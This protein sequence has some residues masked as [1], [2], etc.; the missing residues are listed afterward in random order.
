MLRFAGCMRHLWTLNKYF[1]RY[2]WHLLLGILFVSGS[3]Y[4]KV[5]VPQTIRKALDFVKE[6]LEA[7]DAA[8]SALLQESLL[9]FALT[10]IG[11]AI[12]MGTFMYFMRQTI[13][14]M[15]RLIEYDIRKD[16]YEHFQKLDV[17]F[18]KEYKTGDIM[19]RISEDVSKV[20]MYV[21]P[22]ILYGINLVSL[23]ILVISSMLAVSVK[24]TLYTLLPLPFLSLSIYYVSTIIHKK[25]GIIQSQ[26]SRITSVSQEVYSGI[27]VVKSY[28]QENSFAK[29][30][31]D[32]SNDFKEKSLDLARV[33]ALFFPLMILLISSSTLLTIYIGGLEVVNGNITYGNI[34]EF[35]IYVNYLSWPFMAVGWVASTIQQAEASQERINEFL[36]VA[37]KVTS[38]NNEAFSLQGKIEFKDV[39]FTFPK[40]GVQALKGVSFTLE[41]GQKLA[42]IGKTAS[43]KSTVA[44]LLLRTYDIDKGSILFDGRDIKELNLGEL[45]K[46]IGYVPQDV[47]LFSE[48]VEKN[49][50]MGKPEGSKAEV[51]KYAGHAAVHEDIQK[52]PEQYETFV[53]ERGVTL[54]GGQKQRIS[55]A[56]AFIKEP[57][58]IVLDDCLSAVDTATERKILDYLKNA[59]VDKTAIIITHRVYSLLAFDKILI[60]DDGVIVEEGNHEELIAKNGIYKELYEHQ[61]VE[62]LPS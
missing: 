22:A 19:S 44:E 7:G 13:I 57:Q 38:P 30:F 46:Q 31:E 36:N 54:S 55:L 29:Y 34:A 60:I 51:E 25:S 45:R 37:P 61:E 59:T 20:R 58:I 28:V 41:P 33:N 62:S 21:G 43:G 11:L 53:G 32:E 48:T 52:L 2:K 10:V 4:F 18:Y 24:L 39:H 1:L 16:L 14:V 56:R 12:L 6:Q 3:N 26:L 23:C 8:D 15:S 5:K 49:I 27:S 35:V 17:S 42:I 50:Q 40:S 47:F 9:W